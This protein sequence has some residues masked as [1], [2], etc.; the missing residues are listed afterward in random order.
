MTAG[1]AALQQQGGG[2]G[3]TG[4]G[5]V[6]TSSG[7]LPQCRHTP[8]N[9]FLH[10]SGGR[11]SACTTPLTCRWARGPRV[12]VWTSA[13]PADGQGASGRA[14]GTAH[15]YYLFATCV[16]TTLI[17]ETSFGACGL[18][19]APAMCCNPSHEFSLG[20]RIFRGTIQGAS[21]QQEVEWLRWLVCAA[22]WAAHLP[23]CGN[24]WKVQS[25]SSS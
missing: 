20:I 6:L 22:V 18:C 10:A 7:T 2:L 1:G 25:A 24:A 17:S 4:P 14:V 15:W 23:A 3:W 8:R 19:P 11:P 21:R 13:K 16:R 5:L 9:G 12:Q